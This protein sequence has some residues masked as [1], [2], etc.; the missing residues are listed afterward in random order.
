MYSGVKLSI[1]TINY[2]NKTGL[3]KTLESV[4]NQKKCSF[5]LIVVDGQS[6]DGSIKLIQ[7][8]SKIINHK[9]IENDDGIFDAMNKGIKVSNGDYLL[10]LNSGEIMIE[11]DSFYKF[12]KIIESSNEHLIIGNSLFSKDGNNYFRMKFRKYWNHQSVLIK[13]E[14]QLKYLYD[15]NLK[16]LGD[17][18]FWIRVKKN[19]LLKVK[20]TDLNFVKMILD[21]VGTSEKHLKIRLYDKLY[22]VKKHPLNLYQLLSLFRLLIKILFK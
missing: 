9:F 19:E 7:K 20:N 18:D 1:V 13:R 5:E 8:F 21:G 22:I 17:L 6:T 3:K 14:L 10:F 16:I 2:N 4:S 11:N 12:C 15:T